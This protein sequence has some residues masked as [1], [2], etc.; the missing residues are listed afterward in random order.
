MLTI[1]SFII[2]ATVLISDHPTDVIHLHYMN[3]LPKTYSLTTCK[4]YALDLLHT[5]ADHDIH[6]TRLD[7]VPY[8]N[9]K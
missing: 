3:T 4:K 1:K 8:P 7:C 9:E 6:L 2:V 5:Y